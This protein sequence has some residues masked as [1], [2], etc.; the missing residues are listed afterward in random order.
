MTS[1]SSRKLGVNLLGKSAKLSRVPWRFPLECLCLCLSLSLEREW[2]TNEADSYW[3]LV[4]AEVAFSPPRST[5]RISP[6]LWK[7][8][9]GTGWRDGG[10]D[11]DDVDAANLC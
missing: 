9:K 8:G 5:R 3:C 6:R 4:P 2:V 1:D 11:G 10:R 7:G